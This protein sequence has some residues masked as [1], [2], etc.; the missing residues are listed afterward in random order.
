[1]VDAENYEDKVSGFDL[2]DPM[3]LAGPGCVKG[4]PEIYL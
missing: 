3:S 1:M 2:F 4:L